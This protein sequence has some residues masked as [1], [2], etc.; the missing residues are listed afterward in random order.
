[1][2]TL[3][4]DTIREIKGSISRFLSI[5][6]IIALGICFFVGVKATG[7][8]MQLTANRYYEAQKLMDLRLVSTFGFKEE[9]VAAIRMTQGVGEVMPGYSADVILEQGEK[10]L[11]MRIIS[12]PEKDGL[13]QP[14]LVEGRLPEKPNEIVVEAPQT[15]D[16]LVSSS[17]KFEIGETLK[18]SPEVGEKP[19]KDF[20]KEDEFTIVGF[21]RSPQFVSIERGST[22]LGTGDL[23]LYAFA[24]PEAFAYER[25]TEVYVLGDRKGN[26][27]TAYNNQSKEKVDQ[28]AESLEL[29]G[30]ERLAINREE[31]VNEATQ[32]LNK[33]K[34]ELQEARKQLS[35]GIASG[36]AFIETSKQALYTGENE[37]AIGRAKFQEEMR[38][39]AEKLM[40]GKS[41][42]QRGE[43]ALNQGEKDLEIE[44]EKA[45]L[46]L[47]AGIDQ[48]KNGILQMEEND[49]SHQLPQ[50]ENQLAVI[51]S[52][53]FQLELT[54]HQLVTEESLIEE[55]INQLDPNAPD[56]D[57]QKA[58]LEESLALIQAA[59]RNAEMG[60]TQ[61]N[62]GKEEV[63]NGIDQILDFQK[64]LKDLKN[65]LN[66][67]EVNGPV[68]I[69]KGRIEGQQKI[70]AGREEIEKNKIILAQGEVAYEEGR[71]N[72]EN[73][74]AQGQREIE[75][76]WME[77][78]KG[79]AELKDQQIRGELEIA[80]GEQKIKDGQA[81]IDKIEFGKFYVF[82]RNDNVGYSSYGEDA[83]RIDNM[84]G[85]FPMI[86]L[87]VAAL[88]SFTTMT[89]MVEEQRTQIGTLKALG[90]NHVQI[91][92]KYFIYALTGAMIGA[93]IGA[94]IGLNT[95][96]YL[97]AG[98]YNIL[99][100]MPSL[101]LSIPWIPMM[102]SI[103]I[104]V[105]CTVFAAIGVTYVELK[106]N[107][108]QL[109]RP[110]APK[111]GKEIFLEKIPFIWKRLGFIEKVT[112]RNL[113]RYKG[114]FFMTVIG[115]AGCTAL[116]LAGFG[117]RDAIFS[118][119]PKQ[120]EE[121]SIY[122]GVLAFKNEE[123]LEGRS[124]TKTLMENDPNF[125]ESI[126]VYQTK[127]NLE[128][129]GTDNKKEAYFF[130]PEF[131][132][133]IDDFAK[134]HDRKTQEPI[135]LKKAGVVLSE[136][137]AYDLNLKVGD[138]VRV[139]SDDESHE[140]TVGA[141]TENYLE[142]YIYLSPKVYEDLWK[143]PLKV[144]LALVNL[145][146]TSKETE[147]EVAKGWLE[148]HGV[149]AVNFTAN[150]IKST[151]DSLNTLNV[152]VLVMLFSAGALAVVVL[153]NLTNINISERVREIAT[154]RVLGFYD[155]E[156][157]TYIFRENI[158]L[159]S[160]GIL[161]GLGLG[162]IL[163]NYIINTVE[164]D[165]VMFGRSIE[166][167]SYLFAV[168]FTLFFTFVVNI[169]MTPL[170]KKISMV[171]SLKSI[172]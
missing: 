42:I 150:I 87:L 90:Y 172:E 136:K 121:I 133:E 145:V 58:Q 69:E 171:E 1:M 41:E 85:V 104:A 152:V 40:F 109:M 151:N 20:L 118:I 119:I 167:S 157:Y 103:L 130:V 161:F 122:D 25:Y 64:K 84:A 21:V 82:D 13:N 50:L 57:E 23:R 14:L 102:V 153:Y 6:A 51:N 49:P 142:N 8:S 19:L 37:Y 18:I 32:A 148:N 127:L 114:R 71:I 99:Y 65:Q 112:A 34:Q 92:S 39:G 10:R 54:Y 166:A 17:T 165:I 70:D 141:I 76:G 31:I 159:S 105:A 131:Q 138:K 154:I 96:P 106:E 46:Q 29:L 111:I 52:E 113:M 12:Y 79:E 22:T 77:L 33:G 88:V 9:D 168:L 80:K 30:I 132:G 56:Y 101:E 36:Q 117:L 48:L 3:Q 144:N 7:P 156:V 61:L 128:K 139:F 73:Q 164:T 45:Q 74:L 163:N 68:E 28:L 75:I 98:A 123:T 97:I 169:G 110:K 155:S 95:L 140:V 83:Q 89:R 72:G 143:K 27:F 66:E 55:A 108:S 60:L 125:T 44:I 4:K 91:A 135:D 38:L 11:V 35:D 93:I 129:P 170:I 158:V 146:D 59:M 86:F 26:D 43:E 100:Q 53:I 81:E 16:S 134:L 2:K 126:F 162:I 107:P 24:L 115:I 120:F 67:L 5:M 116:I 147:E 124:E 78:R 94:I 47:V 63:L 149:V 160:I 137:V 15:K 62:I